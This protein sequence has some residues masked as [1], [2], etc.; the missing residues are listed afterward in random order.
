MVEGIAEGVTKLEVADVEGVELSVDAVEVGIE[1]VVGRAV[2]VAGRGEGVSAGDSVGRA[3]NLTLPQLHVTK[4][5]SRK[6]T[7][8]TGSWCVRCS[9]KGWMWDTSFL[10]RLSIIGAL[11]KSV[12]FELV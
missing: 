9:T 1:E 5:C 3:Q 10:P 2:E 4:K 6:W 8:D 11:Y 12:L 7:S